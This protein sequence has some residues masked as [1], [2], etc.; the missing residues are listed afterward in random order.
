MPTLT[1]KEMGPWK[2]KNP[3]H[4]FGLNGHQR[5][6]IQHLIDELNETQ[7]P[8]EMLLVKLDQI[9]FNEIVVFSGSTSFQLKWD[10]V[11]PPCRAMK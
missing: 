7:V 8:I 1:D 9:K 11:M 5:E 3:Y 6:K 4:K 10:D 2:I